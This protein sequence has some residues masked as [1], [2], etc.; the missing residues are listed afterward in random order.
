MDICEI[1][2]KRYATKKFDAAK[3]IPAPVV[4][5]LK[6]LLQLSASSVN[7][8]PWH[9]ILAGTPDGKARMAKSTHG[10]FEYNK[11]KVLQASHVVVF[12][13][14]TDMDAAYLEQLTA[15][16]D[17]DGRFPTPTARDE[18][19]AKRSMYVGLHKND[20]ADLPLWAAKQTYLSFGSFLLGAAA[21]GLDAVAM[22]GFDAQVLDEEFGLRQKHLTS[23]ALMAVGYHAEDDLNA[24]LP[25]SRLSLE[26]ILTEV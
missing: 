4:A 1:A 23:L 22:E 11:S 5:S 16:E 6:E 9:F 25:K 8:Q 17:K 2:R 3:T 12:C 15:Q 18:Q 24:K 26:A 19:H 14:R 10:P 21:L 7:S 20:W 13:G